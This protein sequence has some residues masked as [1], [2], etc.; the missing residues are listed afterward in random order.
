MSHKGMLFNH[1]LHLKNEEG[2]SCTKRMISK[3]HQVKKEKKSKCRV[4][5][6]QERRKILNLNHVD[7]C[8]K[9]KFL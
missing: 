2:F 9:N 3:I 8:S 4:N 5:S 1:T 7:V 6:K